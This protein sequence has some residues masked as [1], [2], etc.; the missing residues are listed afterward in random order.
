MPASGEIHIRFPIAATISP[1]C[2]ILVGSTFD[3]SN[4]PLICQYVIEGSYKYYKITR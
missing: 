4:D 3:A 1:A 2:T